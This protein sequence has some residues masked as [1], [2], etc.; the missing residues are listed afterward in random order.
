[1]ILSHF[2]LRKRR[3]ASLNACALLEISQTSSEV[4]SSEYSWSSCHG[5]EDEFDSN[6]RKAVEASLKDLHPTKQ[7][8]R[9]KHKITTKSCLVDKDPEHSKQIESKKHLSLK[10]TQ[11]V[12]FTPMRRMASLNAQACIAAT[13]Q[14]WTKI[15]EPT[16]NDKKVNMTENENYEPVETPKKDD[17][18]VKKENVAIKHINN[19]DNQQKD[20]SEYNFTVIERGPS[21]Y[22]FEN[23][24]APEGIATFATQSNQ[25]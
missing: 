21:V 22:D 8:S 12:S 20:N 17:R 18:V 9:T 14:S 3:I 2:Q 11:E 15:K 24:K 5:S 19:H 13:N 25:T 10:K 7:S 6:M 23:T 4:S 16:P 1:M